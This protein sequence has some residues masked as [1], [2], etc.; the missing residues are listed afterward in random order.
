MLKLSLG[1]QELLL[2]QNT[3]DITENAWLHFLLLEERAD[4]HGV[5]EGF[6][7]ENIVD[8]FEFLLIFRS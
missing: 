8:I 1:I 2:A 4:D 7:V 5:F 6:D 3:H